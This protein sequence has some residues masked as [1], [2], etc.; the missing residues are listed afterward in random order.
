[1]PSYL[2]LAPEQGGNRFG[3]FQGGA[4]ALGSDATRCQI[5]LALPGI[6]PIH[7]TI[8]DHSDGTFTIAPTQRGLGLLLVQ[9]GQNRQ[10][11]GSVKA[12]AGDIVLVGGHTGAKFTLMFE[13]VSNAQRVKAMQ[14]GGGKMGG[15]QGQPPAQQPQGQG[16]GQMA[17]GM[18]AGSSAARRYERE[19]GFGNAM[20]NEVKRQ[21]MGRA[22]ARLGL[23]QYAQ[24]FYRF[25]SGSLFQPRFIVSALG[26]VVV[27]VGG[28]IFSCVGALTTWW[29]A[30]Q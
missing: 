12:R 15:Y 27:L 9:N 20:A 25:Q 5:T 11:D 8:M 3:P 22:M 6:A 30:N 2:V 4:I 29:A 21:A 10:V 14:G 24:M 13:A 7:A 1:M 18:F 26:T 28:A 17:G 23:A 19:G 16:V